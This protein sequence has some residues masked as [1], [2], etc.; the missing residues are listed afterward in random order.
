[1]THPLL[2]RVDSPA[3]LRHLSRTRLLLH[4]VDLAPLEGAADPAKEA[5]ALANELKKYDPA[6]H[7]KPRWLVFN[8]AD[9]CAGDADAQARARRIVRS[10]RWKGPWFVVA[11]ISGRG[12]PELSAEVYRFLSGEAKQATGRA[13]RA[14]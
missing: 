5:R 13:R 14:G 3:D 8:K 9:L 6:L 11:A 1:M 2:S 10:L 4:L 7:K 12:C